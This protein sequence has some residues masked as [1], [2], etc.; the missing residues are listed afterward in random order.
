LTLQGAFG[1]RDFLVRLVIYHPMCM[2]GVHR[3]PLRVCCS[4]IGIG[5]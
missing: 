2:G 5:W 1:D 4:S 3:P